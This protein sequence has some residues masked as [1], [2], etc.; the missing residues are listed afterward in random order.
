M[1][2]SKTQVS[3]IPEL[4]TVLLDA[5]TVL[6]GFGAGVSASAGVTYCGECFKK[7]FQDFAVSVGRFRLTASFL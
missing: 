6:L 5:D 7:H 2:L 4:Q 3:S 1:Q